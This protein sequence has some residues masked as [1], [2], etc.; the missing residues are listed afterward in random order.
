MMTDANL[1]QQETTVTRLRIA[2]ADRKF[3]LQSLR[4]LPC[5]DELYRPVTVDLNGTVAV[6]AANEDQPQPTEILLRNSQREG[7]PTRINMNR[8]YLAKAIEMGFEELQISDPQAP[9]FCCDENRKYMWAPLD[10]ESAVKPHEDAT[11]IES[12]VQP[13][14]QTPQRR[15]RRTKP[16]MTR[17]T[18]QENPGSAGNGRPAT[19]AGQTQRES[20]AGALE[21]A[22]ALRSALRDAVNKTS[23]L[24]RTLKREQKQS[25]LVRSTL[26]SLKQIQTV[27]V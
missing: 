17:S 4:R 11:R 18:R 21:Q 14:G 19:T 3:L 22:T 12:P 10:P 1:P 15:R 25:K 7:E 2:D 23:E 8:A 20:T 16:T 9:I 6:R 5:D 27:D 24:I 26:A 13:P